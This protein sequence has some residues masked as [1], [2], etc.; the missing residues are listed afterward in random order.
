MRVFELYINTLVK[1]HPVIGRREETY[2]NIVS[3]GYTT[4]FYYITVPCDSLEH[5]LI[6]YLENPET[7]KKNTR[8]ELSIN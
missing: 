6:K 7:K 8:Q 3:T 1:K 5:F 4:P 2:Q